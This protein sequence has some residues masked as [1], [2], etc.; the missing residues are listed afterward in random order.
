MSYIEYSKYEIMGLKQ[1]QVKKCKEA[2]DAFDLD[3]SHFIE[4]NE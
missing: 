2:F 3:N 4:I 1:E